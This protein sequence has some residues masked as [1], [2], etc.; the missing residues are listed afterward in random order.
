[1]QAEQHRLRGIFTLPGELGR[2]EQAR[3]CQ[4]VD[5]RR[6]GGRAADGQAQEP[7]LDRWRADN[8]HP[9]TIGEDG[10]AE[11]LA[12]AHIL[13][14]HGGG[15]GGDGFQPIQ[16][17]LRNLVLNPFAAALDAPLDKHAAG[18]IHH[19]VR[20]HRIGQPGGHR[21]DQKPERLF[22]GLAPR[23]HHRV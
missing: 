6:P 12:V 9:L 22:A 15:E 17:E 20:G 23:P 7:Q 18:F 10:R 14:R 16:I 19:D 3:A 13:F 8:L 1:M 21:L 5:R 11:R 4:A 2:A